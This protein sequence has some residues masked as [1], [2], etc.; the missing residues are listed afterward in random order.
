[1]SDAPLTDAAG[2]FKGAIV[3]IA[4]ISERKKAERRIEHQ[5]THDPLTGIPNRLRFGELLSQTIVRARRYSHRFALLFVDLDCFKEVNDNHGHAV[6]DRVLIEAAHRMQGCLR[7]SDTLGR[8]GGDEFVVLLPEIEG[9][10]DADVV[11]E[12]IRLALV[13]PFV[14]DGLE[15][16]ISSSIGIVLFPE[17]GEDEHILM[18]RADEAMYRAKS[19][20][21]NCTRS[22][23][24]SAAP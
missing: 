4:D 18:R 22:F 15:V 19:A 24:A 7:G 1:V 16:R 23:S 2:R 21:R 3:M 9:S 17:H 20:G 11:A 14:L 8:R 10:E 12:K 13:R 5:A 6:G